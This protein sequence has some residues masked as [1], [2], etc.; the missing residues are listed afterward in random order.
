VRF[1]PITSISPVSK[2]SRGGGKM[3]LSEIAA[4]IVATSQPKARSSGT[5]ITP[6][7]ART[8][9]PANVAANT[10]ASTTQA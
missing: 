6:G 4:E 3:M 7:A 1:R 9:T 2:G 5:I 10:T 8:P